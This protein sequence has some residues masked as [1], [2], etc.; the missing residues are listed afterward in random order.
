MNWFGEPNDNR[1]ELLARLRGGPHPFALKE[2]SQ[3]LKGDKEVV[4]AAVKQFAFDLEFASADLRGDKEVVL[5]AV[6]SD[7]TALQ[8]ASA[9]LRGDKEVVLAA[10]K[11]G[12]RCYSRD[13][14]Y[15]IQQDC[16]EHVVLRFASADLR[17]DKEVVLAAVKSGGMVLRY[18]SADLRGDKEVVLAAVKADGKALR[19]ASV[20]LRGDE[21]VVIE[22]VRQDGNAL[23]FSSAGLKEDPVLRALAK[24]GRN[25]YQEARKLLSQAGKRKPKN[26]TDEEAK[27]ALIAKVAKHFPE[28]CNRAEEVHAKLFALQGP[29]GGKTRVSKRGRDEYETG[30]M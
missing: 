30:F 1:E 15:A 13:P 21:E 29:R 4:I 8:L 20:D 17:G 16:K 6:K 2:A 18:A 25:S 26:A 9:D 14:L 3:R 10:V 7:G 23:N 28:L 12:I 24:G 27:S 19:Y 22:A 11:S 5:A